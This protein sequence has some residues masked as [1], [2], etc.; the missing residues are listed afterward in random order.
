M[1]SDDLTC[2]IEVDILDRNNAMCYMANDVTHCNITLGTMG[3]ADIEW[4]NK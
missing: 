4:K 2:Y 1:F 3:E